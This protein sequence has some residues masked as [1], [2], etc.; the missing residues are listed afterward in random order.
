MLGFCSQRLIYVGDEKHL[1]LDSESPVGNLQIRA[2][3]LRWSGRIGGLMEATAWHRKWLD[4]V[5][6]GDDGIR[7]EVFNTQ[8]IKKIHFS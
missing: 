4:H 5:K 8:E 2:A 6:T 3:A 1:H 7:D